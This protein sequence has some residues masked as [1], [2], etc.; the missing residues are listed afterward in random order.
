MPKDTYTLIHRRISMALAPELSAAEAAEAADEDWEEDR[1]GAEAMT[2]E[3]GPRVEG[4]YVMEEGKLMFDEATG[5]VRL[6]YVEAWPDGMR[7]ALTAVLKSNGKFQ[8]ESTGGFIQK[9]RRE[10]TLPA[11][12]EERL[13]LP[14][15]KK[16][17]AQDG[18]AAVDHGE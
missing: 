11:D 13:N 2:F 18:D 9:A 4:R 3:G 1:A 8:C 5:R 10:D 17:Y 16:Y 6:S 14:E 7:D 12:A 15:S